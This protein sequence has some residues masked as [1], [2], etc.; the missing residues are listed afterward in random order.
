MNFYLGSVDIDMNTPNEGLVCSPPLVSTKVQVQAA[1]FV[2]Y[3]RCLSII[4]PLRTRIRTVYCFFGFLFSLF[5]LSFFI[6]IF[7]YLFIFINILFWQIQYKI[8]YKD[9]KIVNF[10]YVGNVSM[11]Q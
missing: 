4:C 1:W 8:Q 3:C 10:V 6:F 5:S 11:W 2:R 7:I 9:T